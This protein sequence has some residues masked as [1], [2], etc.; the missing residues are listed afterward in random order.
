MEKQNGYITYLKH[1]KIMK[2]MSQ[3]LKFKITIMKL[4]AG[5]QSSKEEAHTGSKLTLLWSLIEIM[6]KI[7]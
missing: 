3:G 5:F 2:M 7:S 6:E 4:A 1:L